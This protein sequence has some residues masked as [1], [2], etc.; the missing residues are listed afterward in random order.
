MNDGRIGRDDRLKAELS[1]SHAEIRF[2]G[3][4]EELRVESVEEVPITPLDEQEATGHDRHFPHGVSLPVSKGSG[5][6]DAGVGSQP[7]QTAVPAE[8]GPE[9]VPPPAT[10]R[11]QTSVL[12][13]RPPPPDSISGIGFGEVDQ[14]LDRPVQNH[15]VGIQEQQVVT[16]RHVRQDIV[17]PGETQ[18]ALAVDD[19]ESRIRTEFRFD[20]I[21]TSIGRAIVDDD[22]L[23]GRARSL[24]DD[25]AKTFEGHFPRVV[26]DHDD[27]DRDV[28]RRIVGFGSSES[29]P[30]HGSVVVVWGVR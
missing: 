6:E 22:Q 30:D 18:I 21:Q 7:G 5:I 17:R 27:R 8:L 14:R 23:E 13:Q 24:T 3:V 12:E 26:G 1:R 2:L 29:G 15:G 20:G 19:P 4:H 25:G 28:R 16:P 11:V 9:R 10:R